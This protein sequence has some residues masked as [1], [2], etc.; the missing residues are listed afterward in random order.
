MEMPTPCTNCDR[1]V[2][3]NNMNTCDGCSNLYCNECCEEPFGL[4]KNCKDYDPT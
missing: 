3:L 4:C 2:E 1:T